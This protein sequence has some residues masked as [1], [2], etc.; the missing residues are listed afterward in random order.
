MGPS[1][2]RVSFNTVLS[3]GAICTLYAHCTDND[4][5]HLQFYDTELWKYLKSDDLLENINDFKASSFIWNIEQKL[6]TEFVVMQMMVVVSISRKI[7][8]KY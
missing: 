1:V 2:P 3:H 6:Q 5:S 7:C 8:N 4:V